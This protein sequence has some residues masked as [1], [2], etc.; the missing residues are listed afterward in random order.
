MVSPEGYRGKY[1]RISVH[2]I[3]FFKISRRQKLQIKP[4]MPFQFFRQ[5]F[6]QINTYFNT[7]IF[8]CNNNLR[9]EIKFLAYRIVTSMLL[10]ALS[11]F[12]LIKRWNQIPLFRRV[13]QPYCATGCRS[14]P[15]M[16]HFNTRGFFI[17]KHSIVLAAEHQYFTPGF[18]KYPESLICNVCAND[19]PTAKQ[20]V[21]LRT[22]YH[23][24]KN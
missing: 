12:R 19:E 17:V 24:L 6:I 7:L 14:H 13:L 9:I 11:I 4:G 18:S 8:C 5:R 15:M 16:D 23:L 3:S 22:A 20:A 10:P 1:S 21:K 2:H